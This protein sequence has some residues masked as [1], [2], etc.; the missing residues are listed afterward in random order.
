VHV[1]AAK[2]PAEK[3]VAWRAKVMN[4]IATGAVNLVPNQGTG[5]PLPADPLE[6]LTLF[7][8]EGSGILVLAKNANVGQGGFGNDSLG[9]TLA[10]I[11]GLT[12]SGGDN[13][14]GIMVNG[15]AHRLEISNNKIQGNAGT[16]GGGVRSGEPFLLNAAADDYQSAFNDRLFLHHNAITRNGGIEGAGGGISL[17]TGSDLY[18]VEDSFICGNFSGG[19]GGGIAHYGLSDGGQINRNWIVFNENF[20]QQQSVNGGGIFV[21]GEEAVAAGVL[22]PGSG[23]VRIDR[24]TIQGNGATSGDGGGIRLQ[25]V[26]GA[27]VARVPN[28]SGAWYRVDITNNMI[29]DNV[30]ALSGGAISLQDAARVGILHNTIVRNDSTATA[31]DAFAPGS[32]NQSTPQPAGIVSRAHSPELRAAFGTTAST[33]QYRVFSNPTLDNNIIWQNRSFYFAMDPTAPAPN[34]KLLPDVAAGQAPVYWDLA[35]LG[36]PTPAT[37][38]PLNSDLTS[39]VGY[40]ATNFSANP[41]LLASYFNGSAAQLALPGATTGI[42]P[43]PAFDEGGNFIKVR[44]G[45]ISLTNPVTGALLANGHIPANSPVRSRGIPIGQLLAYP[46]LLSDFD[47]QPRPLSLTVRP[48][49]GADQFVP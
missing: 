20:F 30:A 39:V 44:F 46:S 37:L 10:R 42:T 47:G 6:P 8:E 4:L 13:A 11:D 29:M 21:G 48:D 14:G 9:R 38:N 35:V 26:N 31:G 7:N 16:Y 45:P 43:P 15:Y 40:S 49:V 3:L 41:L 32:P 28:G 25:R 23:S 2:S 5:L 36:T 17:Y 12:I 18:R 22:S 33:A 24:N 34:F 1:V 19:H 27:D